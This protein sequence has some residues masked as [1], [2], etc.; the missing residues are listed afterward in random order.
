T[1]WPGTWK[2]V[3][4]PPTS[5]GS[6]VCASFLSTTNT[7]LKIGSG[8]YTR[9][10]LPSCAVGKYAQRIGCLWRSRLGVDGRQDSADG[11]RTGISVSGNHH[12]LVVEP[13]APWASW[14]EGRGHGY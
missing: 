14:Y 7:P 1:T 6:G 13:N 10:T 4:M 12:S 11:L 5:P 8:C 2:A 3:K 9:R